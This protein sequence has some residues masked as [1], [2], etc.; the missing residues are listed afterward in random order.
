MKIEV[1]IKV[2]EKTNHVYGFNM[3]ELTAVFVTYH[4][5]VKPK[6][7]RVWRITEFWDNYGRNSTIPQPELPELIKHYAL[8][9]VQKR[10]E[11]KTWKEYKP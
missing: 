11:V 4:E 8:L 6:G 9:E 2:D 7:K 10:V 1:K 5:E 3:F